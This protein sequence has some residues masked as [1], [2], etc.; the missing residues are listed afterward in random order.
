MGHNLYLEL[1]AERG[2]LGFLAFFALLLACGRMLVRAGNRAQGQIDQMLVWV[3]AGCLLV[4]LLAGVIELSL[5]RYW[6]SAILC[7]AI[8]MLLALSRMTNGKTD[9]NYQNR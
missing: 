4:T 6:F 8:G 1:L 3:I 2:A 5:L 9:G 7:L